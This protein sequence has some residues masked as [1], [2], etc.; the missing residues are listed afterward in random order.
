MKAI[1]MIRTRGHPQE[2]SIDPISKRHMTVQTIKSPKKI[3]TKM[4][5]A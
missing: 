1:M 4:T 2:N 3:A 5:G